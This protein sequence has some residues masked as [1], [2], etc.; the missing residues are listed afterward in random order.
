MENNLPKP[1]LYNHLSYKRAMHFVLSTSQVDLID[2][3]K[4]K[5]IQ[6]FQVAAKHDCVMIFGPAVDDGCK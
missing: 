3:S 1:A 2:F 4:E 6:I 5:F